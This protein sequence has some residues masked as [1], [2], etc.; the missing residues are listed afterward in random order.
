MKKFYLICGFLIIFILSGCTVVRRMFR[1]DLDLKYN[2]IKAT[3]VTT[4]GEINFYL[5]PEASPITVANFINLSKRGF[6]NNV[7]FHRAIENFMV[8]GG[9]PSGTGRGNTGYGLP[10][11]RAKWLD[12]FQGGM[13]AMANAGPGTGGSQFFI[14]VAPAEWLNNKHTIFGEVISDSDLAVV[15]RLEVG[16]MIRE[17]RFTGETDF[18]LSMHKDQV[19]KWNAILNRNFPNLKRVP[20]R[21]LSDFP[22]SSVEAFNNELRMI[23]EA[24][25]GKVDE[26]EVKLSP[27]PKF[28]KYV[29]EKVPRQKD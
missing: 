5:Y 14:T 26:K 3:M 19:E 22:G 18:F 17:I 12:F 20:I 13:L 4:Q 28:L 21:P 7:K 6:Y 29:D 1:P 25:Q 8:Q 24:E 23:Q 16:D 10:E 2:N 11:E 27:I 9:D 15:R